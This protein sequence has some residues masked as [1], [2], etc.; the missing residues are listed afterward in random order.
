VNAAVNGGDRL[1][2]K[3]ERQKKEK[4]ETARAGIRVGDVPLEA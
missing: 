4:S 2:E 3:R 1:R